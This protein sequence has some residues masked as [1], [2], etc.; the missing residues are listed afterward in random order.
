MRRPTT[1]PRA[2]NASMRL[3]GHSESSY[4]I[5]PSCGS[6][7]KL[8]PAKLGRAQ[9]RSG[10]KH[11]PAGVS[12]RVR[13]NYRRHA[14]LAMNTGQISLDISHIKRE[15]LLRARQLAREYGVD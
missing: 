14:I 1:D 13:R 11:D 2:L 15:R 7:P 12:V 4:G 3:C 9:Q 5:A 10:H 8:F 6:S